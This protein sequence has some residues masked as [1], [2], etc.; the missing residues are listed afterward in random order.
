VKERHEVHGRYA[1]LTVAAALAAGVLVAAAPPARAGCQDY[2]PGWQLCDGPVLPDGTWQRCQVNTASGPS[3]I[4]STSKCYQLGG[5]NP[6]PVLIG[7]PGHI[8]QPGGPAVAAAPPS[9]GDCQKYG[10]DG[11]ELCDGPV[12]PDGTW[13]RC[14]LHPDIMLQ[15]TNSQCY[16]M[17]PNHFQ[18]PFQTP[19][20]IGS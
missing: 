14:E 15:G 1:V 12:Q 2:S 3:P 11:T 8:D 16:P 17:G 18:P 10:I 9:G 20:H 4:T 19:D 13:Q 7:P 5:N 6:V